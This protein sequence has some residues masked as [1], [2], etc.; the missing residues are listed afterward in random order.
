MGTVTTISKVIGRK[1][2]NMGLGMTL[3]RSLW[4]LASTVTTMV[5]D[6]IMVGLIPFPRS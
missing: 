6:L 4:S 2:G 3:S 5:R 1:N